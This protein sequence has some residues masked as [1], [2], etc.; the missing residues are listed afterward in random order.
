MSRPPCCTHPSLWLG[1][2]HLPW[3]QNPIDR[4]SLT[5]LSGSPHS[6]F[7]PR[8]SLAT[9]FETAAYLSITSYPQPSIFLLP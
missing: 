5:F 7:F 9:L 1:G 3:G 2:I 4:E 6:R 8:P